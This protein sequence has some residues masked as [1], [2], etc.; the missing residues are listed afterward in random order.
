MFLK[1]KFKQPES[2]INFSNVIFFRKSQDR[3]CKME[4]KTVDKVI[5]WDYRS[6]E[7]LE[8]ELS[9]LN[10]ILGVVQIEAQDN[11]VI[12][13]DKENKAVTPKTKKAKVKKKGEE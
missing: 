3:P 10:N 5:Y 8:A 9:A 13:E 7:E 6:E 2:P 11:K 1:S 4:I 12:V